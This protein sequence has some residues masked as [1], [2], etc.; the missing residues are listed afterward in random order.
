[1]S[2]PHSPLIEFPCDYPVKVIGDAVPELES[3][4]L[5]L[6]QQHDPHFRP[7]TLSRQ[8]SRNGRFLSLRVI[9]KATSESQLKALFADLKATGLVHMVL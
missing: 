2:K 3:R 1:M 7:E 6:V 9:L 4:V 5:A 8:P